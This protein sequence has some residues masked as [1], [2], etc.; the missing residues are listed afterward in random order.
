M[1]PAFRWYG[2]DDPVPLAHI[3]QIPGMQTIV[4][5][6]YDV[7]VG[8]A[9]PLD[10]LKI[11]RDRVEARA[12]GFPP[13]DLKNTDPIPGWER[14]RVQNRPGRNRPGRE[15]RGGRDP[16][17]RVGRIASSSELWGKTARGK[18]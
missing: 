3:R 7:P 9:W 1:R 8:E 14:S 18:T 12:A 2:P 11:L 6:L 16:R 17:R 13:G 10:A 5:A 4:S 15:K